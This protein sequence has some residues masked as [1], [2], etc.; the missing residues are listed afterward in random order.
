MIHRHEIRVRQ[1]EAQHQ[2][3]ADDL[4]LRD[5][6]LKTAQEK[7][8]E[9]MKNKGDGDKVL[10]RRCQKSQHFLIYLICSLSLSF[11]LFF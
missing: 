10:P 9:E 1:L 5:L 3:V 11:L 8:A 2:K 6:E 7:L 4:K